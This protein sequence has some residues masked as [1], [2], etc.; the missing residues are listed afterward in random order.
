MSNKI[1]YAVS[2]RKQGLLNFDIFKVI[3]YNNE[4]KRDYTLHEIES[5]LVCKIA[6]YPASLSNMVVMVLDG[7]L[8][9]MEDGENITLKISI[10]KE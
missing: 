1:N 8:N 2:M 3:G 9:V 7:E 4:G 6:E 10:E 5:Y